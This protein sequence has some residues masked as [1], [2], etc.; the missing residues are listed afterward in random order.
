M[1]HGMGEP[2]ERALVA[3]G[4]RVRVYTPYGAM[5]PGMA[6]LVRRLLE[7]TSNE[8]FLKASFAGDGRGRRP[9]AR[10]R[11]DRSHVAPEASNRRPAP[12]RAATCPRSRNEPLTDFTRPEARRDDAS[13]ARRGPRATSTAGP[14]RRARSSST[15]RS[16]TGVGDA[17]RP[18]PGRPRD[19]RSA[20][21]PPPGAAEADRGRRPAAPGVRRP[22]RRPRLASGPRSCSGPPRSSAATGSSWP[23]SRSSSAA[24]P[25][26]RPTATS[27]RRSTSASSTPAR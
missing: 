19:P 9:L 26:A 8:S 23:R 4:R 25:G 22:G 11:G 15:A 13:G 16:S 1:L 5:L 3:R 27:P 24:S 20:G 21:P 17:R 10:P 6:Y 7:N 12:S 14:Y 2:I 18:L